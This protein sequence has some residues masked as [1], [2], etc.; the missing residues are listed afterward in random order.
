MQ[1]GNALVSSNKEKRDGRY[2][3]KCGN[4]IAN[5]PC[6]NDLQHSAGKRS[7]SRL[8]MMGNRLR[9]SMTQSRLVH[10]TVMSMNVIFCGS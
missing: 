10:L 3:S 7:F 2:F 9:T 8:K 1:F 5:I 6:Y 4:S